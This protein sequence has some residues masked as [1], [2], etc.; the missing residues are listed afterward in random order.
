MRHLEED[1]PRLEAGLP[2]VV[3]WFGARRSS[4]FQVP[5]ELSRSSIESSSPPWITAWFRDTEL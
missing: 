5:F 3:G 2:A 4:F 1:D